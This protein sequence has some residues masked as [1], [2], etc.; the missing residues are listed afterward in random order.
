MHQILM[1]TFADLHLSALANLHLVYNK[2]ATS[3]GNLQL[4]VNDPR[5]H[6]QAQQ[7]DPSSNSSATTIV[8][9]SPARVHGSEATTI[10]VDCNHR[11]SPHA[12]T[13][14]SCNTS[15]QTLHIPIVV[16]S[17]ASHSQTENQCATATTSSHA[18]K[19]V[20]T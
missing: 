10:C 6:H 17:V 5:R 20:S 4:Q 8:D 12:K 7:A 19:P 16:T 14:S 1:P 15:L 3:I 11:A 2:V 13:A 18:R 9:C